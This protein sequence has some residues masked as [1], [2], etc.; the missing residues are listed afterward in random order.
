MTIADAAAA[1]LVARGIAAGTQLGAFTLIFVDDLDVPAVIDRDS[2]TIWFNPNEPLED[3]I[4]VLAAC[5]DELVGGT[6]VQLEDGELEVVPDI[7]VG[8]EGVVLTEPKR[9]HLRRVK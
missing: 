9:P 3:V 6:V 4:F 5:F 8:A 7:A 2:N 1:A